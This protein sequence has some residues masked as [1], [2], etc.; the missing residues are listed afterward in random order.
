MGTGLPVELRFRT[1]VGSVTITPHTTIAASLAERH[2]LDPDAAQD[3]V[4][5]GLG[6]PDAI[7]LFSF[8]AVT[9]INH[10]DVDAVPV[11][12]PPVPLD[13]HALVA[14]ADLGHQSRPAEVREVGDRRALARGLPVDDGDRRSAV[15]R[16]SRSGSVG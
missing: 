9:E 6:I 13:E 14:T 7:D 4:R 11:E 1:L 10:G 5:T 15:R 12:R 2:G 8:D 16:R 3:V